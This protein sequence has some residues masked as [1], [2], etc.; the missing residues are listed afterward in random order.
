M[1]KEQG[2]FGEQVGLGSS[3]NAKDKS[4]SATVRASQCG[5]HRDQAGVGDMG[6]SRMSRC[7]SEKDSGYS[8]EQVSTWM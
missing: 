3:K 6:S 7:D 8:G 1:P 4:N 5:I 2:H